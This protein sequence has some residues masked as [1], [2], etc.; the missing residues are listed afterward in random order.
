MACAQGEPPSYSA[1][2]R[3]AA[4]PLERRRRAAVPLDLDQ[5][6]RP[7][8]HL[9]RGGLDP[10]G[11]RGD[12]QRRRTARLSALPHLPDLRQAP[13]KAFVTGGTGFVGAHLVQTLLARGAEVRCLVRNPAKALALG[14]RDVRLVRGD[15]DD[16]AALA[17]GCAGAEL[18]FHLAGRI[19]AR[20]VREFMSA[21]RDGTA[22]VLEA[23][24]L[25]PPQRFVLVSSLAAGGPTTPGHPIDEERRPAPVTPYGQSKLAA[26]IVVRAMPFPWTIVR[27]PAVYGE[28]DRE[29]LKVFKLARR[30]LVP[31]FGDGSQELSVVYAGDLAAALVAAATSPGAARKVYY[32]AHPAVTT[33][34]ALVRAVGRAVGREPRL[35]PLPA[36]VAR[37]MLW[38]IGS[39]AHLAGRA[40]VLSADKAAE[41][42]AP[43]WTCRPDALMRDTGW[44]AAT[45]LNA[46]LQRTADW[47]RREGWL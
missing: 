4:V 40:T 19:S 28:R 3:A 20:D 31:V 44:S 8:V 36:P 23:A 17:E 26:E 13:V 7:W 30:G 16:A 11:Q 39:L 35:L 1:A 25:Q 24:S 34:A 5:G 9:G 6:G 21:N 45:D 27:P 46:G 42:L 12:E 2:R 33:S 15:L 32:A 29:T 10:R 38:A 37:V 14:W 18:V 43:A 22:S 41:F 47:Y